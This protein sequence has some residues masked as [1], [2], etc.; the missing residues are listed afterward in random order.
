VTPP[1]FLSQ[2]RGAQPRV[3]ELTADALSCEALPLRTEFGEERF[4][5]L[6]M[7]DNDENVVHPL[8]RQGS[9]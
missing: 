3:A 2:L 5:S 1:Q 9:D 7:V 6:E 8:N 4:G